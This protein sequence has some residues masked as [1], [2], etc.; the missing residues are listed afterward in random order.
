MIAASAL[1][2]SALLSLADAPATAPPPPAPP[3]HL[4]GVDVV[5]GPGPKVSAS[6]PAQ[7][8]SAPSGVLVLKI[9]FDQP[10]AAGDWSY[11]KVDGAAFPTC[12][13]HPR[14]LADQKTFVLLC[15]TDPGATYAVQ[16]NPTPVFESAA[17]RT[18]SPFVLRF[19]TTQDSTR[20]L[21]DALT[22]ADLTDDDDP[23]MSW[24]DGET[25]V[26]RSPGTDAGTA[27]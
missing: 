5:A 14:L 12:L 2:L 22:Q 24:N 21:H 25:G 4:S 18:A 20:D 15:T 13:A 19:T 27:P 3:T 11:A 7:G 1:A 10:M 6:Y 23:I 8:A 16:I 9:V 26:S 17:G